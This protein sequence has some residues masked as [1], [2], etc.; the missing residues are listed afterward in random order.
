MKEIKKILC[1]LDPV[2]HAKSAIKQTLTLAKLHNAS[3]CFISILKPIPAPISTLQQ[4]YINIQKNT[5]NKQLKEFGVNPEDHE[6]RVITG[7][8][9]ALDIVTVAVRE[10][11]DLIIKPTDDKGHNRVSIFGSNDQQLFRKSSV[12]VWINKPTKSFQ[13]KRLL[14][15][16]DIDPEQPENIELNRGIVALAKEMAK[17]FSA[18]LH[19]VHAYHMPYAAMLQ[20]KEEF[21]LPEQT[22]SALAD[23]RMERENLWNDFLTE[24][25]LDSDSHFAHF[26]EGEVDKVVSDLALTLDID[27]VVMGTVARTGIEGFFIGNTAEKI[28][29]KLDCSVLAIKPDSFSPPVR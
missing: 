23:I 4:T 26:I 14:A 1:Y 20:D 27:T 15:A 7:S 28:L 9:G 2:S 21:D 19:V 29:S 16:V 6:I 3:I 25:Q 24:Y 12:P 13:C 18:E 17:A 5:I 10:D 11:F 8:L 22:E